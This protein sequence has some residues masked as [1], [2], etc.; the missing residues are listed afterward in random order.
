MT[1]RVKVKCIIDDTYEI[2]ADSADEALSEAAE[3]ANDDFVSGT[4]FELV[5]ED[6][7]PIEE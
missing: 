6:G 2:E 3:W 1:Y 5:D 7:C 4:S